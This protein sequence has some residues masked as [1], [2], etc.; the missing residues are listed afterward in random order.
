M[1]N[2]S[3]DLYVDLT[4]DELEFKKLGELFNGNINESE[5]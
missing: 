5:N 3:C 4:K 1:N 2:N